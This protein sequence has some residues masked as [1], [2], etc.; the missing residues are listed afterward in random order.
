MTETTTKDPTTAHELPSGATLHLG[1]PPFAAAGELRNALFRA[2]GGRPFS[3][4]EMK[5]G[6]HDLAANPSAG[7]ALLQ[8]LLSVLASP[9]VE[10]AVFGC[11]VQASYEPAG[12]PEARVK[13]NREL[14][15]HPSFGDGAREDFYPICQK[16]GE[17]ALRPFFGA[18]L[19]AFTAFQATRAGSQKSTPSSPPSAS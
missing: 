9:D 10:D 17:A 7:G 18:L 6:L 3:P 19:S 15:D 5:L 12:A 11:L 2:A 1:R 13:V 16:A 8:R 4:D 14:L